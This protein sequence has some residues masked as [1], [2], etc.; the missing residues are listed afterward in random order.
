MNRSGT[1]VGGQLDVETQAAMDVDQWM[2]VFA[3]ES[4]TGINDTYNQGLEHNL[5]LYVRPEDQRVLALPWDMDFSFHQ[6]T[7]MPLYGTGSRL[8]RVIQIPTTAA[9]SSN[10]CGTS[11]RQ[12]T[13][14]RI[15]GRGSS[16]WVR[17]LSRTI[18]RH[19]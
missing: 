12:P 19:W 16:I 1:A 6:A 7:N 14:R 17:S 5:Q 11:C 8:G 13:T 18:P 10:T 2:R 15:S 3:L 9:C 4:L